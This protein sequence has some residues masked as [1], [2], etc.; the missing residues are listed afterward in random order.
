MAPPS[1]A[2]AIRAAAIEAARARRKA[3]S[4]GAEAASCHT[5]WGSIARAKLA[6]A[7]GPECP[8]RWCRHRR[9]QTRIEVAGDGRS[10]RLLRDGGAC[11]GCCYA[12][13]AERLELG[14]GGSAEDFGDALPWAPTV[15]LGVGAGW[16][17]LAAGAAPWGA[18][19]LAA[20][21]RGELE[22]LFA[23]DGGPRWAR[24]SLAAPGVS[25]AAFAGYCASD[26]EGD[27]APLYIFD[28]QL[29]RRSFGDGRALAA[30]FQPV[31]ACFSRDAMAGCA[32]F[33]PL[34]PAWLLLGPRRSGTPIHDH[35][36]TVAWNILLSGCKLWVCLPP[37]VDA[38]F[39][40]ECSALAW[41]LKY[42]ETLP[43]TAVVIVQQVGETVFVPA[44]W[45]HV[46]LNCSETTALSHSLALRR[47]FKT[48]YEALLDED[49][50]FAQFWIGHVRGL[51]WPAHFLPTC[52]D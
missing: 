43:P 46:V 25:M 47:D 20:R 5:E 18:A 42:H 4:S 16:R 50:E 35:P 19:A 49:A 21:G 37:D 40:D 22:P 9:A 15:L 13:N 36:H 3:A 48:S 2:A 23:V 28:P 30:E 24:E 39:V 27:D 41:F 14:A 12:D 44:G 17:A 52:C 32:R 31:P 33:R 7:Q 34:P 8:E 38:N 10:V 51:G 6:L 45:F 11:G 29:A 1:D 26:G